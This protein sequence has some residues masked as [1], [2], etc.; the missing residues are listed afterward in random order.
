MSAAGLHTALCMPGATH[1][2]I[3]LTREQRRRLDELGRRERKSLAE[4]VRE[5]V[6]A[7]LERSGATPQEAL[8]ATFGSLPD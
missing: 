2:Q 3:S 1:T 7:Y 6:E 8:R 5:A 4:L